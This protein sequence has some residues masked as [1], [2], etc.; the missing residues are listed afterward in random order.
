MKAVIICFSQT[1]NTL[2]VAEKIREGVLET[3]APVFHGR[4]A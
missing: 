1:G 3:A 2:K 4:T